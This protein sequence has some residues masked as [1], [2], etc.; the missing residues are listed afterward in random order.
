MNEYNH[1]P[2]LRRLIKIPGAS[3]FV[4]PLLGSSCPNSLAPATG[5]IEVTILRA[6]PTA[7]YVDYADYLA[8]ESRSRS[9]P[10]RW[11]DHRHNGNQQDNLNFGWNELHK[12]WHIA[13]S[14]RVQTFSK[15]LSSGAGNL[16]RHRQGD[17]SHAWTGRKCAY[18]PKNR[19][20][21]Q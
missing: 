15:F 4:L 16:G 7:R 3:V 17:T 9:A 2:Y 11:F 14:N 5:D 1:H 18:L 20:R 21:W 13:I 10:V 12:W 8:G 19:N 6:A